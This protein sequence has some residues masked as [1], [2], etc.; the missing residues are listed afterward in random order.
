MQTPSQTFIA[1]KFDTT[2]NVLLKP[3]DV[4]KKFSIVVT[5]AKIKARLEIVCAAKMRASMWNNVVWWS[6]GK[7]SEE[8]LDTANILIVSEAGILANGPLIWW[9]LR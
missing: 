4:V 5:P 8:P 3:L 2:G 9:Q 6:V 7:T 1:V